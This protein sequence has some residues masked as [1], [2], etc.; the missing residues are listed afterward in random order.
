M[1]YVFMFIKGLVSL[2]VTVI[3]V[4]Y[5]MVLLNEWNYG[6]KGIIA[7]I[8]IFPLVLYGAGYATD[9]LT[10]GKLSSGPQ[11]FI[12]IFVL[13]CI[14]AVQKYNY[15]MKQT[16][17]YRDAAA[18][19]GLEYSHDVVVDSALKN[20]PVFRVGFLGS[21]HNAL[22]GSYHDVKLLFFNFQYEVPDADDTDHYFRSVVVYEDPEREIPEFHMRLKGFGDNIFGLLDDEGEVEFTDDPPF[23]KKYRVIGPDA[24][25]LRQLFGPAAQSALTASPRG[26]A[27][28]GLD[29]RVIIYA[30][31]RMDE[32]VKP[33]VEAIRDYLDQT[34]EL[35]RGIRA[36]APLHRTS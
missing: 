7:A 10:F 15:E 14:G 9:K 8:V 25:A 34:W 17:G 13:M 28:A 3:L 21:G 26:W 20:N 11:I 18:Y 32:E 1:T 30:D 33:N 29:H 22:I 31:D 35:Y 5:G 6:L 4:Y 19:L 2:V 24:E 36:T 23:S 16:A 12:G 27:I